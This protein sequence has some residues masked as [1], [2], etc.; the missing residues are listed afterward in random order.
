MIGEQFGPRIAIKYFPTKDTASKWRV[1][2]LQRQVLQVQTG[3]RESK[4]RWVD[5][6]RYISGS[7]EVNEPG[8]LIKTVITNFY[9]VAYKYLRKKD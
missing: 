1:S 8:T 5:R 6:I 7:T 4:K 2:E 3:Q 9:T